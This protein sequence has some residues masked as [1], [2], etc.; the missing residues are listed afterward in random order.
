M[1]RT[2]E[3]RIGVVASVGTHLVDRLVANDDV[4]SVVNWAF[5]E[6]ANPLKLLRTIRKSK[7][8]AVLINLESGSVSDNKIASRL[9]LVIPGLLRVGGVPTGVLLDEL[10]SRASMLAVL[11]ADYVALSSP[12]D[13]EFLQEA[14][15]ATNVFVA[16]Q[17]SSEAIGWHLAQLG[18][19]VD[20]LPVGQ[21]YH[22]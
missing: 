16:P 3:W 1:A 17:A 11:R 10:G 13:V 2:T 15:E 9:G 4:H 5:D 20:G 21:Q 7:V 8:D 14:Y 22:R 18:D 19:V 6:L 12:G